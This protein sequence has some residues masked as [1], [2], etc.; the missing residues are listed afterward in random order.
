M[1]KAA[2]CLRRLVHQPHDRR[3]VRVGFSKLGPS[4]AHQW[5]DRLAHALHMDAEVF[6]IAIEGLLLLRVECQFR[7]DPLNPLL[8]G[9]R[10]RRPVNV[11]PCS[12]GD[13]AQIEYQRQRERY[14]EQRLPRH[15]ARYP[16]SEHHPRSPSLKSRKKPVPGARS[17]GRKLGALA[18]PDWLSASDVSLPI[19]NPSQLAIAIAAARL[20]QRVSPC[21]M[22]RCRRGERKAK[23]PPFA[24]ELSG[25]IAQARAITRSRPSGGSAIP[26]ASARAAAT[27]AAAVGSAAST[28]ATLSRSSVSRRPSAKA[29]RSRSRA[30]SSSGA[31]VRQDRCHR[32]R[33]SERFIPSSRSV[34]FWLIAMRSSYLRPPHRCPP[35]SFT[36]LPF[37]FRL[38]M[39]PQLDHG[40]VMRAA[41]CLPV[42]AQSRGDLSDLHLAIVQHRQNFALPWRQQRFREFEP[43]NRLDRVDREPTLGYRL[44][45]HHHPPVAAHRLAGGAAGDDRGP[46]RQL[47]PGRVGTSA[48]T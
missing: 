4:S 9:H 39:S 10:R 33:P 11:D 22:L 45:R 41:H 5:V 36:A 44:D 6:S 38:E 24:A 29:A 19:A 27:S 7:S 40:L 15:P 26:P 47:R 14:P 48:A 28:A 8:R 2:S 46:S 17:S 20:P 37:R 42:D 1:L 35:H 12:T 43:A 13:E 30:A 32:A 23:T 16:R 34:S 18:A 21:T 31:S 3:L 25:N